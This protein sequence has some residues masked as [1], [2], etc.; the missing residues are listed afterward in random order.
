M[1]LESFSEIM[2][3]KT[4][5]K[6]P[7]YPWQELALDIIKELN[8]PDFKKSS[9]FKACKE[10]PAATVRVALNDTKELCKKGARWQY[11]FKVLSSIKENQ[12]NEKGK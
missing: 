12:K 10:N 1:S 4:K 11:F 8:P 2:K 9:V 3:N 5:T 7:A 6:A